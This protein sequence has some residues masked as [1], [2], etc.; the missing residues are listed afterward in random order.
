MEK[1]IFEIIFENSFFEN[2]ETLK[3]SKILKI[4][5]FKLFY[6]PFFSKLHF[7]FKIAIFVFFKN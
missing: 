6:F 3:I 7:F 2:F 1:N 5:N 4:Q